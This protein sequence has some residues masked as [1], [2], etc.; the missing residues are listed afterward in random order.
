[1]ETDFKFWFL[2]SVDKI[3]YKFYSNDFSR[4]MKKIK[5]CSVFVQENRN[6]HQ[7]KQKSNIKNDF[8]NL[9]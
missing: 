3:S 4:M 7:K 9:L 1:M 2:F 6:G 5:F 8:K